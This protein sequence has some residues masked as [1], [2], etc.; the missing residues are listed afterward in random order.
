MQ[1]AQQKVVTIDYVLT[2]D[3]GEEIDRS[4]G[5]N[6]AYLHGSSNIISGLENA[7]DGKQAGDELS[8]NV[9]AAEGYGERDERLVQVISREMFNVNDPV[10]PGVQFNAVASD[11]Q[12]VVVTV[13][14][15]EDDQ[16]T[17]DGNHPLAGEDLNFQVKVVDVRDATDEELSHGHVH[18]PGGH[19]H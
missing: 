3:R 11:G 15:V 2:N 4:E 10:E 6:F 18:G 14:K 13:T 9:A 16:V 5:G 8:V 19:H 1:I 17:I 12:A 7:L